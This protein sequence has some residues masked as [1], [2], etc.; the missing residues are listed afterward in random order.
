MKTCC[1][2]CPGAT[3]TLA[4]F[5]LLGGLQ[6]AAADPPPPLLDTVFPAGGAVG[7]TVTVTIGGS[8]LVGVRALQ[9]SAPGVRSEAAGPN[10]FRL[11]IP[12]GVLPG[13]YDLWAEAENGG[14]SVRSFLIGNR[15][16]TLETEPNDDLASPAAAS[17]N[18]VVH[19]RIEKPGD[20]DCYRF[21]AKRGQRV[22]VECWAERIDSRLRAVLEL[23]D[24]AGRRIAA[25]RGYFGVDPLVDLLAPADGAYVVKVQDLTA[26]GSPEH[27][28]RLD[29]DAGPRVAFTVPSVIEQG[30]AGRVRLFGWNLRATGQP[31]AANVRTHPGK[32]TGGRET[33]RRPR[34]AGAAA[35]AAGSPGRVQSPPA[36]DWVD[37]EIPAAQAHETALLP[38]HRHPSQAL[39]SGLAYHLRGSHAVVPIGVTDVPVVQSEPTSG[40][41]AVLLPGP[42]EVSGVLKTGDDTG[43]FALDAR[44]GE[45]F[46]VEVLARRI[47]S[48]VDAQLSILDS[49]GER[50]F[51]RF[52]DDL[53]NVGG[54]TMPTQHPDPGGRWVAPTDGR[55]RIA[56]RDVVGGLEPDA[57]RIYRLS[58]RREEPALVVVAFPR[59]DD[60]GG[61]TVPR[62]GAA[63]VE[64]VAFRRRG[65]NGAIRVRARDLPGGIE[66][67][68]S[69]LGPG[70]DRTTLVVR[71][72][73]GT[74]FRFG[75][76][77]L[78]AIA[79]EPGA[80]PVPV[81]SAAVVRTGL[82]NG[83]GRLR[84][85][86]PLAVCGE[87]PVRVTA[88]GHEPIPHHLYGVLRPHHS[89][90]G[91]LDVAISIERPAGAPAAAVKLIA[92]GLPES[93]RNQAVVLSAGEAKGHLSFYLPPHLPTG[94]YSVVVR[95]ETTVTTADKK[96]E[97]AVT[98]SNPVTFDVEP[99]A[100]LV[101]VDPYTPL[102]VKRGEIFQIPYSAVRRNGFIGKIHTELAAPGVV[103]NV[104]GLRG[105]GETFVGGAEKGSLQVIVNPDAPLGRQSF[106]RLL[107]VG[108]VEDQPIYQGSCFLTL[109]IVP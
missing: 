55:Y 59:R 51:V 99:A 14:S 10:R 69:W 91:A 21:M 86:L 93:I 100:F 5:L 87:A 22:V 101:E 46:Y 73:P 32:A 4:L 92:V 41:V 66:C 20:P 17:L 1:R 9:C 48:P 12:Q 26:T 50:E 40:G 96:T 7:Q 39:L 15:P 42:C 28:Y 77:K 29:I 79:D 67:P 56:V 58:V 43:W 36:F 45:V 61:L 80:L 8:N 70:V 6:P 89:P 49:K 30:K 25:N 68:E 97:T 94:H 19:G 63:A 64:L 57:R 23:Y 11:T 60:A 83:W 72:D 84:A 54:P 104:T 82:P 31:G 13:H 90:G 106:L 38:V 65:M 47:G 108:T 109:E 3:L 53:R 37:V 35:P 105:R 2:P 24:S 76:L 16:E 71:A 102:R 75:E 44:R 103:T 78:E 107:G 34:R 88:D 85:G 62:G 27:Y 95:A 52:G 18:G 98:F 74:S 33:V 81:R